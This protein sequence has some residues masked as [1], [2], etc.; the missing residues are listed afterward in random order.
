M[1]KHSHSVL[2]Q[3][4]E[5][6]FPCNLLNLLKVYI[7]IIT[8]SLRFVD[9]IRFMCGFFVESW[10]FLIITRDQSHYNNNYLIFFE[11]LDFLKKIIATGLKSP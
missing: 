10:T 7:Y 9:T 1:C 8:P 5:R 6:Y 4:C 11:K 3:N 2:F